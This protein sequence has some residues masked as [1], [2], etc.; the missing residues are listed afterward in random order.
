[1]SSGLVR[2]AH[3][4]RA[5]D[6]RTS[7]DTL[8][9]ELD[10]GRALMVPI[11]WY[12]RLAHATAD[13]RNHWELIGTGEG[14]HWPDLDEDLEVEAILLGWM[15]AESSASLQRWL[16]ARSGKKASA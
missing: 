7:D 12:P 14:I 5:T 3:E 13:E 10:D 15:S 8:T 11:L 1:M 4:V 16:D 2:L 6:V 9:L